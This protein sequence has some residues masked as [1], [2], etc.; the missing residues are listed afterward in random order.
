M[1]ASPLAGRVALVTGG[2]SGIGAATVELLASEGASVVALD[3]DR[4][5]LDQVVARVE[6]A[7]GVARAQTLDLA[8][9]ETIPSAVAEILEREGRIDILV[10]C[11]GIFGDQGTI[12]DLSEATWDLVHTVDLKAPFLLIQHVG[13]HMVDRGGGGRIVNVSSSSAF[14]ARQSIA[15]YGAA[16]AGLS[17]L[18]R[19][20]AADLGRHDINVNAVAPGLTATPMTSD[21]GDS[22]VLDAATVEGPLANLLQ[23]VSQPEDVAAAILFLC[24]PASRQITG[25]TIHTSAGAVTI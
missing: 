19:S 11:A 17:Q 22:D 5:G 18:T 8:R 24:L 7:G 4:S 15:T 16:K 23:R 6:R 3:R 9:T 13:R 10:N 21:Y 1:E 2:A 12:L 14:R 25:Q 20:A